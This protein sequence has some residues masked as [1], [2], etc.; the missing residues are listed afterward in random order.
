M[1][2]GTSCILGI[3]ALGLSLNDPALTLNVYYLLG[4]PLTAVSAYFVLRRLEVTPLV[5]C[6]VSVVFATLPYHF[7]RGADHLFLSAYFTVPIACYLV[8]LAFAGSRLFAW[9]RRRAPS[10]LVAT[11]LGC[12]AIGT[13][14]TYYAAF[15]ASLLLAGAALSLGRTPW[16]RKPAACWA[17]RPGSCSSRSPRA[18]RRLPARH[19]HGSNDAVAVRAPEEAELLSLRLSELVLPVR[20]HRLNRLGSAGAVR[21]E[22]ASPERVEPGARARSDDRSDRVAGG[23]SRDGGREAMQADSTC[24]LPALAA[25]TIVAVLISTTGGL[26]TVVSYAG[27][28]QLRGWNRMSIFIAFFALAAVAILL[29]AARARVTRWPSRTL[30]SAALLAIPVLALLDQTNARLVPPH[31]V[32]QA[33]WASDGGFVRSVEQTLPSGAAVFQLPY[34]SF[35]EEPHPP[36]GAAAYDELVGYIHSDRLRWSFGGCAAAT[37]TGRVRSPTSRRTQS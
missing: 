10:P 30:F 14:S 22:D 3:D 33:A 28:T 21:D 17:P 36:G 15:A 35:P 24:V 23:R 25:A 6:V 31:G 27:L 8:A 4:Y 34:V 19:E 26:L 20:G 5:A 32:V 18:S 1:P 7:G 16:S 13:A 11:V 29:D 9:P 2:P 37:P 12:I